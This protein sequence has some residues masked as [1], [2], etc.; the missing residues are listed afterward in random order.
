MKYQLAAFDID[1]TLIGQSRSVPDSAVKAIQGLVDKG[2]KVAVATSRPYQVAL[3]Q[4]E[5]MGVKTEALT[6]AGADVRLSD[7]SVVEQHPMAPDTAEAVADI[8]DRANWEATIAADD[9]FVRRVNE[10]PR[11]TANA[12]KGM[13]V[14]RSFA[15]N[16]PEK[17]LAVI[18]AA[19][20]DD[21]HLRELKAMS[22]DIRVD[23]A[24]SF[25]GST[26]FTITRRG[27]DKGRAIR[28]LCAALGIAPEA[29]VAFG[30][31]EVDVP[32][33]GAAGMAVCMGN[34][35]DAAKAAADMVTGG[36]EEDGIAKAV[37][38]IWG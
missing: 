3:R 32:M 11:W 25:D 20:D 29:T 13:R 6:S 24:L 9:C 36:V 2:V 22:D 33:F 38:E 18:I 37:K 30:D 35:T 10:A 15:G 19:A 4:F 14:V 21:P 16:V 23:R 26:L 8:C 27:V 17:M 34:G 28:A 31:S 12:P 5:E 1:G 7:G